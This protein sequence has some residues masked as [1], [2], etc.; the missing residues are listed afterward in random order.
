[1][2][3]GAVGEGAAAIAQAPGT[4]PDVKS[5]TRNRARSPGGPAGS[6]SGQ[7]TGAQPSRIRRGR[8][9][10]CPAYGEYFSIRLLYTSAT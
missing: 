8:V 7:V 1:M 10:T 5:D 9:S 3:P 2:G 4:P 6:G